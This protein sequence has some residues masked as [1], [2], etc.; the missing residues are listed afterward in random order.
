MVIFY[1]S[2]RNRKPVVLLCEK[3]NPI[4]KNKTPLKSTVN[5]VAM[6]LFKISL[7]INC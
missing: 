2:Y 5:L 6:H 4:N 7:K 1:R 3:D